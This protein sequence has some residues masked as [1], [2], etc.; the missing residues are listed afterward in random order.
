MSDIIAQNP[1]ETAAY[2]FLLV[3]LLIPII[4]SLYAWYI[5]TINTRIGESVDAKIS[6]IAFSIVV[7]ILSVVALIS[8]IFGLAFLADLAIHLR[9][10][11]KMISVKLFS[12]LTLSSALIFIEKSFF[13]AKKTGILIYPFYSIIYVILALIIA[14]GITIMLNTDRPLSNAMFISCVISI[15]LIRFWFLRKGV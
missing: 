4:S 15:F 12:F 1:N 3:F 13:A 9:P 14:S 11:H 2:W 7:G 5:N 6:A 10:M 8:A